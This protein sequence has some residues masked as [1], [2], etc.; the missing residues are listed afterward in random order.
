[1]HTFMKGGS[2]LIQIN[3]RDGKPIYEQIVEGVRRLVVT[4]VIQPDEKLPSVRELASKLAINPNTICRAYRELE[5][6]GYVYSVCGK[7]TFV[8][9][10][11]AKKE[12]WTK[13]LLAQFDTLSAELFALSVGKEELK[14]R[15]EKLGKETYSNDPGDRGNER[16]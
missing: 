5:K 15:L 16:I 1:M 8:V 3:Y 9:D 2:R 4:D 14:E 11:A 10:G 12:Q 7:G 13:E 6:E